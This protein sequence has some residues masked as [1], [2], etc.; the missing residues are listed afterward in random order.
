MKRL[1]EF[2]CARGPSIERAGG[3]QSRLIWFQRTLEESCIAARYTCNTIIAAQS[4]SYFQEASDGVKKTTA[5]KQP[6]Q[7]KHVL[8]IGVLSGGVRVIF[9]SPLCCTAFFFSVCTFLHK[10]TS[11]QCLVLFFFLSQGM[12]LWRGI[13][14]N[15]KGYL[16]MQS[17]TEFQP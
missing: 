13:T 9:F 16:H 17:Y 11:N 15:R 3:I 10:K 8:M 5:V 14:R 6:P 7:H 2:H 1:E 4:L 12:C